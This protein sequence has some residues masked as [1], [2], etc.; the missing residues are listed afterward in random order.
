MIAAHAHNRK[1]HTCLG[2]GFGI[3][4]GCGCGRGWECVCVCVWMRN[5][6]NTFWKF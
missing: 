5:K 2:I 1:I 3:G 6:R 4:R